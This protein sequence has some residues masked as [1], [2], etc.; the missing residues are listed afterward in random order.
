MA[1]RPVLER[2][3]LLLRVAHALVEGR[4]LEVD[5]RLAGLDG[6]RLLLGAHRLELLDGVGRLVQELRV[7]RVRGGE[8]EAR[9]PVLLVALEDL[10]PLRLRLRG[11]QAHLRAR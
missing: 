6:A 10:L 4:E 8:G 2:R 5:L 9:V 11:P 1:P 7:A 3:A